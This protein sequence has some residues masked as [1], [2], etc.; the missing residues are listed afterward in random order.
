MT[1]VPRWGPF[2]AA[3]ALGWLGLAGCAA[4]WRG[5]FYQWAQECSGTGFARFVADKPL[6]CDVAR[7]NCDL[8][9]SIVSKRTGVSESDLRAFFTLGGVGV[10]IRA[11]MPYRESRFWTTEGIVLSGAGL[12]LVHEMYH[13]YEVGRLKLLDTKNHVGWE[14][15]GYN[16]DHVT[17]WRTAAWFIP[18]PATV[19]APGE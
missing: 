3:L 18:P 11:E 2:R 9:F 1:D 13:A 14:E 6:N 7:R 12:A 16:A 5:P 8:A 17:Y 4:G 19:E 10:Q 15:L